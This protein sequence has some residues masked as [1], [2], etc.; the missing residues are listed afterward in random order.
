MKLSL[1]PLTGLLLFGLSSLAAISAAENRFLRR[2]G[3]QLLMGEVPFRSVGVNKHELLDMYLA[4]FLGQDLEA[5]LTTARRSLDALRDLGVN[6]IRVR[7]SQFWPA[8]IEKTYLGGDEARSVFWKRC[9]MMLADCQ[10]RGLKVVLT[11]AWHLGAWPDLGHE[12]LQEFAGNPYSASCQLFQQWVSD[13]VTRYRDNDTILFWELTNEA[14]LGADLRPQFPEGIIPPRD[15]SKPHSHI[16]SDPVV[17][18][19]RNHWSSEE[20]A[21]FTR[22][23]TRFIKSL[24]PN[25]LVGT[26]FSA[27]RSAAWHLWMVSLRRSDRMD[28]QR[29]DAQEQADYL[30]LITPEPVDLIS[31]HYYLSPDSSFDQIA[32]IKRVADEMSKPVYCGELGVS[33]EAF[34]DGVYNHAGAQSGLECV[35]EAMQVLDVPLTLLWTWDEGTEPPHEPVIRPG[36]HP[37][38]I[39]ILRTA[40]TR[41]GN[42]KEPQSVGVSAST[43]EH[44]HQI[45]E[46]WRQNITVD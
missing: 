25:H 27:P 21:A 19:Q 20:L 39:E 11:I 8:Q 46:K 10:A 42:M 23:T 31:F 28:W 37:E 36:D 15:L 12:S 2:D 4:D 24:D 17:R 29:D 33:A 32:L 14:N 41:A 3:A 9:D 5:S 26:G 45:V 30:R 44:L 22:E 13:L 6:V 38:A 1:W 34:P 18:D 7:G 40:Q 35:L 43:L 16:V